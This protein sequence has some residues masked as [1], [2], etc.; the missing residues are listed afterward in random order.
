M[1]A[2]PPLAAVTLVAADQTNRFL[3]GVTAFLDQ[4]QDRDRL[5]VVLAGAPPR[6]VR[7]LEQ[8]RAGVATDFVKSAKDAYSA[9]F[10]A[11]ALGARM[12]DASDR[13][14]VVVAF[15]NTADFRSAL[16][17]D[18]VAELAK[19]LDNALVLVG[20]PVAINRTV[21][22]VAETA[23]ASSAGMP[24]EG[25]IR[26]FVLPIAL[27]DFAKLSSSQLINLGDPLPS[28]SMKRL[29]ESLRTYYVVTYDMPE[30]KGWHPVKVTVKRRGAKVAVRQGYFVD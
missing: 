22:A 16:N 19:R 28:V 14:R 24:V 5:G 23:S 30:G 25:T 3:A 4:I 13:R 17:A 18:A 29:F 11:I 6:P 15:T 7:V 2:A 9:S 10:D 1:L 20:L 12:F 8:G 26:G 21:T 27:Q